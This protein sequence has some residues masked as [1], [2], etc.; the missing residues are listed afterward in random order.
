MRFMNEVGG[1][2]FR[3]SCDDRSINGIIQ[4]TIQDLQQISFS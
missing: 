4:V 2:Q 3:S 1:I